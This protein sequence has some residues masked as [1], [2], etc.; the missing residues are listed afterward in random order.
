MMDDERSVNDQ[1]LP[2]AEATL[3]D[4]SLT[5]TSL[6]DTSLTDDH[7][8]AT[9]TQAEA[10]V[11]DVNSAD[12]LLTV[13]WPDASATITPVT[14]APASAPDQA[15]QATANLT[16]FPAAES[17]T[18]S[19]HLQES[20]HPPQSLPQNHEQTPLVQAFTQDDPNSNIADASP[21]PH[22]LVSAVRKISSAL[23]ETPGVANILS[24]TNWTLDQFKH[25]KQV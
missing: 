13:A 15:S 24:L 11:K 4:I 18:Q 10:P 25:T 20:P 23:P 3:T 1:M 6:T 19:S 8:P 5:D 17:S 7:G 16:E 12:A 21:G 22:D 9:I 14:A 2:G